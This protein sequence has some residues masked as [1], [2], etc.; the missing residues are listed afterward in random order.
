MKS[1][2]KFLSKCIVFNYIISLF[3]ILLSIFSLQFHLAHKDFIVL[4]LIKILLV[5]SIINVL[6][7]SFRIFITNKI[8]IYYKS[9]CIQCTVIGITLLL[10][11]AI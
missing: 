3:I 1:L 4:N 9:L 5:L 11:S 7:N 2:D 8:K 10:Y 6:T